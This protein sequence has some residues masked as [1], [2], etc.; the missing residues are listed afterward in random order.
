MATSTQGAS[1][2]TEFPLGNSLTLNDL[3]REPVDLTARLRDEEPV[4]WVPGVD[5]W[6]VCNHSLAAQLYR[7]TE[8]FIKD[9]PSS[10][11]K[12]HGD[13][14]L[15]LDEPGHSQH[16]TPFNHA[17]RPSFVAENYTDMIEG[18][19]QALAGDLRDVNE[20]DLVQ[21]F[22]TLFGLRVVRDVLGFD[23]PDDRAMETLLDDFTKAVITDAD[24]DLRGPVDEQ[25]SKLIP[26]VMQAIESSRATVL[27]TFNRNRPED[28]TDDM[29][30]ANVL[31]LVLGGSET[32]ATIVGTTLWALLM[33]PEVYEEVR[34][35]RTLLPA[36]AREAARWH[37]PLGISL[38]AAAKDTE[39]GGVQIKAGERVYPLIMAANRDPEAFQDPEIFD[40]HRRDGKKSVSF[41]MGVHFCI[42]QNVAIA[43]TLSALN[44]FLDHFEGLRL[45]PERPSEPTG[46]ELHTLKSLHVKWDAITFGGT[47]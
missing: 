9:F 5:I 12:L 20:A 27:G 3:R 33:H 18:H 34:A 7:D 42:G 14:M 2:S 40:I 28:Y 21:T 46:F 41:G 10:A 43:A 23:F 16:R 13:T 22:T 30:V 36:A 15:T 44:F 17:F 47:R 32:T 37:A 6:Y 8:N 39:I 11:E 31:A 35:D 19:V 29:V 4:T 1:R 26:A 25:R 38:R 45:D 24:S